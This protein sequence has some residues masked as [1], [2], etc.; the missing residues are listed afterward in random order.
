MLTAHT[1]ADAYVMLDIGVVA[2]RYAR[3]THSLIDYYMVSRPFE[4]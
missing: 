2:L 3:P 4:W 1:G